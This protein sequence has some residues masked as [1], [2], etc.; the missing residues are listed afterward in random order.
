MHRSGT[1]A[2]TGVLNILGLNLGKHVNLDKMEENEKGFFENKR[3]KE[4]NDAIFIR[5]NMRWDD[6]RIWDFWWENPEVVELK[7]NAIKILE[8]E[9]DDVESFGIKDPRMCVTLPFWQNILSDK[10]NIKTILIMRNPLE[11][12]FSLQKRNEFKIEK[13]LE[14]W[15]QYNAS[16]ITHIQKHPNCIVKFD[17]LMNG[18][19]EILS[20]MK[21]ALKL[22]ILDYEDKKKEVD[23]FL[24][25]SLRHFNLSE[26]KA[27]QLWSQIK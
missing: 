26:N 17:D 18:T 4:I 12:A 15:Y 19:K 23:E 21:K 1:S 9:F 24:T 7:E 11:V 3:V 22:N 10:Y 13:G 27:F 2:V 25:P 14:L 20:K 8:Y 6:V 5:L 16:A